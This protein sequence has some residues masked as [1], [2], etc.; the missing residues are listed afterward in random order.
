MYQNGQ[1]AEIAKDMTKIDTTAPQA[2]PNNDVVTRAAGRTPFKSQVK[3]SIIMTIFVAVF[4]IG[5]M[6]ALEK[7]GGLWTEVID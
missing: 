2:N 6:I 7:V 3:D 1:A 5:G 4:F